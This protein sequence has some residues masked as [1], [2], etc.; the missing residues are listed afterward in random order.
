[1]TQF[2]LKSRATEN[3]AIRHVGGL[4]GSHMVGEQTWRVGVIRVNDMTFPKNQ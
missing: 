4:W 1:M 2:Y 3:S